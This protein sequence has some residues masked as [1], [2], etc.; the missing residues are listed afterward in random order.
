MAAAWSYRLYGQRR[1]ARRAYALIAILLAIAVW[2]TVGA[3]RVT[4]LVLLA[5]FVGLFAFTVRSVPRLRRAV[6]ANLRQQGWSGD[7]TS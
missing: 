7:A 6:T 3:F 2:R 5:L 1:M 4:N